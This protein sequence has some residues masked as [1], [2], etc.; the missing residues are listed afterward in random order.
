MEVGPTFFPQEL[1][2]HCFSFLTHKEIPNCSQVCKIWNRLVHDPAIMAKLLSAKGYQ[3]AVD[4]FYPLL[5]A[6]RLAWK[7]IPTLCPLSRLFRSVF[8]SHEA[9]SVYLTRDSPQKHHLNSYIRR[10]LETFTVVNGS[11]VLWKKRCGEVKKL[12]NRRDD[13][14][15]HLAVDDNFL[16]TLNSEGKIAR[17]DLSRC[18]IVQCFFAECLKTG[19]FERRAFAQSPLYTFRADKRHVIIFY[20]KRVVEIIPCERPDDRHVVTPTIHNSRIFSIIHQ[21][22]LYLGTKQ[23]IQAYDLK[24]RCWEKLLR[25]ESDPALDTQDMSIQDGVIFTCDG[26]ATLTLFWEKT[27][28]LIRRHHFNASG[29]FY[30]PSV[31][32]I[33]HIVIQNLFLGYGPAETAQNIVTIIDLN[34]WKVVGRIPDLFNFKRQTLNLDSLEKLAVCCR[35]NISRLHL[36]Y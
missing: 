33:H 29:S 24:A 36:S 27:G 6:E 19:P 18:R 31:K 8:E 2:I 5:Q 25:L 28:K 30:H 35:E 12:Q 13:R 23:S 32:W 26:V 15:T 3:E 20:N 34:T 11:E 9:T 4:D 16:F 17:W 10:G 14:L 22:K 21:E 1:W 7:E